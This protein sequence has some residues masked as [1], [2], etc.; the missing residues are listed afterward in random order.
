MRDVLL[1]L[2]Y[3]FRQL[4][5]WPLPI[6]L[7]PLTGKVGVLAQVRNGDAYGLVVDGHLNMARVYLDQ[8]GF[9]DDVNLDF[10]LKDNVVRWSGASE[11]IRKGGRVELF[12]VRI[13]QR[14]RE[15]VRV[16]ARQIGLN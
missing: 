13:V 11:L 8:Y 9:G 10:G 7:P 3:G 14:A 6:K 12:A 2:R 1:D 16:L 4:A 5:R 15:R